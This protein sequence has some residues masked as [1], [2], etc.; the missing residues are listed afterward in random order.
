MN[1]PRLLFGLL[2]GASLAAALFAPSLALSTQ[3][4][5]FRSKTHLEEV[6]RFVF[7][8]V[9]PE[10]TRRGFE[11]LVSESD[12]ARIARDHS[13]DMLERDYVDHVNPDGKGTVE[14]VRER[15]R[16][17]VGEVSENIWGAVRTEDKGASELAADLMDALME[18][19]GHR[20]NILAEELP[21]IGLGIY[22]SPGRSVMTTQTVVTQLFAAIESYTKDAVP[23]TLQRGHC[24]SVL[25]THPDG[26]RTN[27]EYFD[28][29]SLEEGRAVLGPAPLLRTR[30]NVAP[31]TYQLRFFHRI[32]RQGDSRPGQYEIVPGPYVVVE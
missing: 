16:R 29:W 18:S 20:R 15:H 25:M 11:A 17:L 31:G 6:E 22:S 23:E 7:D 21:H 26:G 12:L 10:R 9:N 1:G 32:G 30:I 14:R 19:P 2:A 24:F 8:R 5:Q 3:V 13:M 27:V 28:L 4:L